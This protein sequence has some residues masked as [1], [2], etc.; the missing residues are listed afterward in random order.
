MRAG[1]WNGGPVGTVPFPARLNKPYS[2]DKKRIKAEVTRDDFTGHL[3]VIVIAP[4][5]TAC[6]I[7]LPTDLVSCAVLAQV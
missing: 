2:I 4:R 3:K 7:N 6:V 1:N 5:Y